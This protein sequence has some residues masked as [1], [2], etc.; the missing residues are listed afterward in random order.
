MAMPDANRDT[1]VPGPRHRQRRR[2]S[3]GAAGARD[4]AHR[5]A[6]VRPRRLLTEVSRQARLG[7]ELSLQRHAPS[8]AGQT[9]EVR[10][11]FTSTR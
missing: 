3:R 2:P 4:P 10:R 7:P 5:S 6:F 9:R 11:P 1:A 8:L